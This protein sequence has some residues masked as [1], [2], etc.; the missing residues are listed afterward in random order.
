MSG[1]CLVRQEFDSRVFGLEFFRLARFDPEALARE[2]PGLPAPCMADAKLPAPDAAG[3]KALL[4]LGF[5]KACV[6]AVFAADLAGRPAG[7]V[8]EPETVTV[9]DPGEIG[10]H[11]A[12]F[13]LSRFGL[14]P[15]V[16]ERARQAHQRRWIEN[17]L[18]DPAIA[19]FRL[20]GGFASVKT[21]GPEAS[22][23]LISV[24]EGRRGAGAVLLGRLQDWAASRGLTRLRVVT[25]AENLPACLFYQKCGLRLAETVSVFHLHRGVFP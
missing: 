12:N 21:K 2:L 17:S 5:A 23:D 7:A 3:A 13:P 18:A 20:D 8:H 15:A 9:M 16:P 1:P 6:Q 24:L 11:A 14:D 25:E 22:I 10:R 19:V 4:R